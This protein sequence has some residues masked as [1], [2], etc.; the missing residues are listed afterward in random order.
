METAHLENMSPGLL[1]KNVHL[2]SR[3][4]DFQKRMI[5]RLGKRRS[6]NPWRFVSYRII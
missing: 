1:T 4:F 2:L 3:R 6:S 5:Y